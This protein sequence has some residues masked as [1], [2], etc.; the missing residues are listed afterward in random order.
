MVSF[1]VLALNIPTSTYLVARFPVALKRSSG[2]LVLDKLKQLHHKTCG[3]WVELELC[4]ES[5]K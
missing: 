1:M 3:S 2:R 5:C 4:D